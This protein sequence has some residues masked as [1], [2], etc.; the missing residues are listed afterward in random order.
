MFEAAGALDKLEGFASIHGA[1]FYNLPVTER[2]IALKKESWRV[3]ESLAF[4]ESVLKPLRGG[5]E[6]LWKIVP[7]DF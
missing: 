6:V 7:V 1:A 2:K 3:P 5:E 4:G